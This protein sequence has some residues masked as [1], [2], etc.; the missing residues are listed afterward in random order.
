MK[1]EHMSNIKTI[2]LF[3][4][5]YVRGECIDPSTAGHDMARP[6]FVKVL[7]NGHYLSCLE[8]RALAEELRRAANY[9]QGEGNV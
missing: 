3:D 4:G 9:V 7:I 8:A 2:A 1:D 6:I 5:K